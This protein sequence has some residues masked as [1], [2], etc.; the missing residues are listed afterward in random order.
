MV[1]PERRTRAD[2]A[3]AALIVLAVAVAAGVVWW[4]SDVRATVSVVAAQPAPEV[5]AARAVPGTVVELWRAASGATDAPVVTAATVATA[6]GGTVVGRDP[7]TGTPVWSYERDLPLCGAVAAFDSVVAVHADQRGCTQVTALGEADGRRGKQ[8]SS[9]ADNPVRLGTE[10]TY[11]L[12]QGGTR[13]E[14]WRSDLVRTLEYGRVAA[15]VHPGSQPREGCAVT[16]AASSRARTAVLLRCPGEDGE[17]LS[18]VT[19]A[20]EDEKKPQE[21]GSVLLSADDPQLGLRTGVS[22][23]RVAAVAGDRTAVWVPGPRASLVVYD[24]S[25]VRTGATDLGE[26]APGQAVPHWHAQVDGSTA[27]WWSGTELLALDTATFA[28]RWRLPGALGPGALMAD[29]YLVPVDGGIAVLDPGTGGQTGF[30]AVT[31][32]ST[33]PVVLAVLGEV[34]VEQRGGEVV[35]L[36]KPG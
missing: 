6:D 5:P 25:A 29:R 4:R 15:P 12:S 24:G 19:P 8:R 11:V 26:G 3:A 20:P 28:P 32:N 13:L 21:Q 33:G 36:G 10:G 23:A 18:L 7:R 30:L 2:I 1:A 16:D 14:L 17:R 22:G 31:R 9:D 27:Y 34:L 35:A